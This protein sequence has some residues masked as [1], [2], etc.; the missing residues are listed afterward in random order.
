[1]DLPLFFRTGVQLLQSKNN[2]KRS[3]LRVKEKKKNFLSSY[4]NKFFLDKDDHYSL[5]KFLREKEFISKGEKIGKISKVGDGNMNYVL[6][7]STDDRSF[8]LKQARPWVEKYPHIAAPVERSQV[9]ASYYKTIESNDFLRK[10]S[11]QIYWS[12]SSNFILC[13]EDLGQES[14]DMTNLY[15]DGQTHVDDTIDVLLQY[16]RTLHAANGELPEN[17]EMRKLNHEHIFHFPFQKNNGLDL[18]QIQKGLHQVAEPYRDNSTLK[19]KINRLGEIYLLKGRSIIHGDF[20]PGSWLQCKDG[21]RVID[22]EFSFNGPPEFDLAVLSAHLIFAGMHHDKLLQILKSY[23]AP[24]NFNHE[25]YSGF[26]GT[27]IMRRLIGVAQLP[28][29]HSIAQKI[30]LMARANDW[31][32]NENQGTINFL[33]VAN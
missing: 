9:E 17:T 7:I 18:D 3:L 6:R 30:N 28:L 19:K 26:T 25:L 14:A 21:L 12:D 32:M 1:M 24:A 22:P 31:I 2:S 23:K 8:I 11:P 5:E 13:M 27:E 29:P 4:P 20:Y 16:L 15:H 10:C 33:P